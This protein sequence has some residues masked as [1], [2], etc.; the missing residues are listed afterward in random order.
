MTKTLAQI[1]TAH[2][3]GTL[4]LTDTIEAVY[5][6]IASADDPAMFI[7]L[8]AKAEVLAEAKTLQAAG[9]TDLPLYGI[10]FAVK[11]NI[12]VAGLPTSAACPAFVHDVT[13]DATSV[14]RLRAAGA[15]VI[16]KT[17]LDQ[18]ATGLVG[19]RSP[20]GVPKNAMK[21][22]LVPGGSSSGSAVAVARGIVPF[23]LGTD[24]AGSGRV[25]AGLNNIVGLKP[26]LGL[27]PNTGMVPACR[28]LDCTSVFAL[29]AEDALLVASVMSGV[30]GKDSLARPLP[31][32]PL[33][34]VPPGLIFGVPKPEQ[35]E[36]FGSKDAQ[37][38]YET[39]L[40]LAEGL[41]IKLVDIDMTPFYATAQ[42][43]YDGPWVAERTAALGDM[44]TKTPEVLHPVTRAIV[45]KGLSVSAVDTFTALYKL[46]D[47]KA[48]AYASLEGLDGLLLPTAPRAYT[49]K[50]LEAEPILCNSRLGTYTNFV[51]LLDLCGFA[52]PSMIA[53][54]GTPYGVTFL[55][56]AGKD[57]LL[58]SIAAAVQR[59][60]GLTLGATGFACPPLPVFSI[61]AAPHE[62]AIAVVGA[63]LSGQ[64]LNHQLTS[65]GGRLLEAGTTS[66]DYRFYAL[67]GGG[68]ARPGLVRVEK[69]Q[70]V[71]IKLEVW[72]LPFDKAARFIAQIPAPLGIGTVIL[73]DGRTVQGFLCE[74]EALKDATDISH[75]GGW[76]AY[77]ASL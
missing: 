70:G 26:S 18:F 48:L 24:T 31:L 55:A 59:A 72:A 21:E 16:G 77:R 30:D 54:D 5:S 46:A 74:P 13:E 1:L 44:I 49:V 14:A 20:Y 11:D 10:P 4:A 40:K 73:F 45:E 47:L 32:G 76:L 51:N 22:G 17:N 12:D 39:G 68:V 65:L 43:L 50:E 29:T 52:V 9:K 67:G 69:G 8:R 75:F 19:V 57:A 23:S 36:F 66:A 7:A 37:A 34:A 41:G 6:A 58:A 61:T 63:H 3:S 64:P 35:R 62:Y 53:G 28:T 71:P 42:L 56:K 33:Q 38:A 15:I 27:I 25:P 2:R 60:N